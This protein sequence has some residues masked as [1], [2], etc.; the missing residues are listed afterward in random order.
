MA[1]INING[2]DLPSP[3]TYN[4]NIADIVVASRNA[5]GL[6]IAEKKAQKV[7]IEL[8]WKYLTKQQYSNIL[9]L[10]S[11]FFFSATFFNPITG[12]TSTKTFYVGDRNAGLFKYDIATNQITGWRDIKFNLIER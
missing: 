4:V 6:L 1:L 3:S 2:T 10:F 11:S 8:E 7:K 9:S 12:A 5:E